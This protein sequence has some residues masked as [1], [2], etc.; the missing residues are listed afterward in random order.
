MNAKAKDVTDV[1]CVKQSVIMPKESLGDLM[2]FPV[3]PDEITHECCLHMIVIHLVGRMSHCHFILIIWISEKQ[4]IFIGLRMTTL[5]IVA[6]HLWGF[7]SS[8]R[9]LKQ[10]YSDL[11]EYDEG[12][13][14]IRCTLIG[15]GEIELRLKHLFQ[16]VTFHIS[17]ESFTF[18]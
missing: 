10:D 9:C 18:R 15:E 16:L 1:S 13:H 2:Y 5:L 4:I 3:T 14:S 8:R 12:L 11:V 6:S 7:L 17:C